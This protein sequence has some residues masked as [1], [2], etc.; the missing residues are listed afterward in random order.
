MLVVISL[1]LE[2][3]VI[4]ISLMLQEELSLVGISSS[5]ISTRGGGER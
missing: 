1:T 2:L 4:T 5:L 3:V